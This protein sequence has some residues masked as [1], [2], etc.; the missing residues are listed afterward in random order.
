[1]FGEVVWQFMNVKFE[2]IDCLSNDPSFSKA[3][4]FST[5]QF[6]PYEHPVEPNDKQPVGKVKT[7]DYKK[8]LSNSKDLAAKR[9]D[10][11]DWLQIDCLELQEYEKDAIKVTLL[12]DVAEFYSR[13]VTHAQEHFQPINPN[14]NVIKIIEQ[15]RGELRAKMIKSKTTA[16]FNQLE[17]R[18]STLNRIL[19][20]LQS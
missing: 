18:I 9:H 4:G 19:K 8:L 10:Y 17:I 14:A 6:I 12:D 13:L 20:L 15:H 1:M 7:I 3:H 5:R 16:Y 11:A 2:W